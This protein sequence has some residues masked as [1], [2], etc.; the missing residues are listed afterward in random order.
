[1]FGRGCGLH[2]AICTLALVSAVVCGASG[3][4]TAQDW[5]LETNLAQ[6]G[7][8]NSNLLLNPTHKIDAF[9]SV[10]IP[11]FTLQRD[12][13]TSRISLGGQFKFHEYIN[14]SEL[15]SDSQLI[16]LTLSRDLSER[17]TFSLH[18]DFDRDTTLTSD[19][20]ITGRFL[21]KP[22]RVVTWGAA[23]TWSY[24][25]SPV[26]TL[27][28]DGSYLL[29]NYDSIEKTDYQYYGTDLSYE[30]QLSEVAA[31]T[32]SV[33]YFRYVPDDLLNTRQDIYGAL[34]GY[35]YTPN[36][37]FEVSGSAG[38]DYNVT[39]QDDVGF[40]TGDSTDVGYRVKFDLT[41]ALNDQTKGGVSLSHDVQPSGNARLETQN[42]GLLTLDYRF[43]EE[44]TFSLKA[45][46]IDN[47]DYFASGTN[48]SRNLTRY[49]SIGPLLSWNISDALTLQASYQLRHKFFDGNNRSA[50]DNAA[51]LSI[52]YALPDLH[53][54]GF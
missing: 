36:E 48:G 17:S 39:H 23:P 31:I 35:R 42:R 2:R 46:Y 28:W 5:S 44:T 13:P 14:R 51:F 19:V 32:G 33:S 11:E 49:F 30:H 43:G 4:A 41:Y 21:T 50:T 24:Q 22:V 18:G 16:N 34:I 53:W 7:T 54:S 37:R 38:A 47:Q 40:D 10:S 15:N 52:Q 8:Y 26:D 29:T 9:G 1:M 20:D 25:L 27:T 45:N 3:V 6:R 12:S